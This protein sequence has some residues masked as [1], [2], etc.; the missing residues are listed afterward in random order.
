M[1]EQDRQ[2]REQL[3]RAIVERLAEVPAD[4]R[5]RMMVAERVARS[6]AQM[7]R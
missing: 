3:A 1:S 4:P 2:A 6:V 7:A 5:E